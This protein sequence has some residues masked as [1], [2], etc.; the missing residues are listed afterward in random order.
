MKAHGLISDC[1]SSNDKFRLFC[2]ERA[3]A[4]ATVLHRWA[5]CLSGT[6]CV[7]LSGCISATVTPRPTQTANSKL[8]AASALQEVFNGNGCGTIYSSRGFSTSGHNGYCVPSTSVSPD[9]ITFNFE[10]RTILEETTIGFEHTMYS[11]IERKLLKYRVDDRKQE[12]ALTFSEVARIVERKYF[13]KHQSNF[14]LLDS[15]GKELCGFYCT[16]FG[17]KA[18]EA[19]S[20]LAVL[21]SNAGAKPEA[22]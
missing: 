13:L 9:Y 3:T 5:V 11:T 10:K 21:C 15:S 2:Q 4:G 16:S 1:S 19:R 7:L 20:S 17:G 6:L 18:K 14:Y 8:S 12:I 22:R